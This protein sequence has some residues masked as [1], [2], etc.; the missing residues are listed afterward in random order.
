MLVPCCEM[1]PSSKASCPKRCILLR[2]PRKVTMPEHNGDSFALI[3]RCSWGMKAEGCRLQL[4]P[5]L[6]MHAPG[7]SATRTHAPGRSSGLGNKTLTLI[8]MQELMLHNQL[9]C[10]QHRGPRVPIRP[11]SRRGGAGH[12]ARGWLHLPV[13]SQHRL[14]LVRVAC[15]LVH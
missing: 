8:L 1:G 12:G 4:G 7:A 13:H 15:L 2:T 14:L 5:V 11:A 10:L 6:T 3:Y 9:S